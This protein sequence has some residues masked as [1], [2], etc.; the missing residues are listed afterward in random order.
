MTW[1]FQ[2][3]LT[4]ERTPKP[5]SFCT[6]GQVSSSSW[7]VELSCS[8]GGACELGSLL[9][10]SGQAWWLEAVLP[11][12]Q[13]EAVYTTSLPFSSIN[14]PQILR[15]IDESRRRT[16]GLLRGSRE[17]NHRLG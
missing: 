8:K 14:N 5:V 11:P 7:F 1:D 15:K 12:F 13:S 3:A 16:H 6:H 9:C 2:N 4:L 17:R 10:L